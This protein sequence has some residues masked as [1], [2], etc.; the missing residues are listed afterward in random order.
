MRNSTPSGPSPALL[1]AFATAAFDEL[2]LGASLEH[3]GAWRA[4]HTIP[5]VVEFEAEC[6][7]EALRWAYNGRCLARARATSRLVRGEHFGFCDLFAPI[8]SGPGE[9][10][11]LVVGPF[12]VRHS[13]GAD[14]IERWGALRG[15]RPS[16]TEPSFQ[17]YLSAT[18]GM[19]TLEGPLSGKLTRLVTCCAALLG[20]PSHPSRMAE[21][22]ERLRRELLHARAP[23]QMW[24]AARSMVDDQTTRLWSTPLKQDP[25]AELG[26]SRAPQHV[27]VGLV[28]GR[29]GEVDLVGEALRV[30]AFQR[31]L[32]DVARRGK[33]VVAGR[34]G[35]RGVTLLSCAKGRVSSVA[36]ELVELATRATQLARQ[37][38]FRLHSGI[39]RGVSEQALSMRYAAALAAAERVLS[40]GGVMEIADDRPDTAERNLAT[41]RS[42]LSGSAEADRTLL[43]SRFERYIEAVA[44]HAGRQLEVTRAYLEAGFERLAE[45][46][47]QSGRLDQR[48]FDELRSTLGR[49]FHGDSATLELLDA[50]RNAV[51]DTERALSS[52]TPARQDRGIRR[53][54]AFLREH[55]AEPLTVAQVARASGFAPDYLRKIFR[56]AEGVTLDEYLQSLRLTRA[57]QVLA[58]TTFAMA[59]VARLSGFESRTYFQLWFRRRTG[60]TPVEYRRRSLGNPS[61]PYVPLGSTR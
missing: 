17:R 21:E 38:G 43:G 23:E 33:N 35:D 54:L 47:L 29:S 32:T 57:Q 44:A 53:A 58:T 37:F 59:R 16:I 45:P 60:M 14:I 39:A 34:I 46:L 7:N 36:P 1:S 28:R 25:L 31:A 49:P 19:L 61:R 40:K 26:M 55:L 42:A 50:Y 12:A 13:T 56:R 3:R 15:E 9:N 41:L 48:S 27:I 2:G 4:I 52:P 11:V 8:A 6:G 20:R 24:E 30:D 51:A 10:A 5:S 22:I 18:L